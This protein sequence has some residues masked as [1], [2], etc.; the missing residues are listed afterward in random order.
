MPH[1]I[2]IIFNI[3]VEEGATGKDSTWTKTTVEVDYVRVYTA[4][5]VVPVIGIGLNTNE[6]EVTKYGTTQ[7]VASIEP[8][9]ASNKDIIWTSSNEAIAKVNTS[10]VVTGIANGTATITATTSDGNKTASC[11][12]TVAGTAPCS[13]LTIES[14]TTSY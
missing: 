12:V 9:N 7:L 2:Y 5:P 11:T 8:A 3:A 10:G 4:G 6:T 14:A 13:L 1:T